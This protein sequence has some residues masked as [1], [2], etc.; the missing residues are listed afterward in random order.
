MG[1]EKNIKI[2]REKFG[3]TVKVKIPLL[4]G[5]RVR[6]HKVIFRAIKFKYFGSK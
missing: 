5:N 4:K 3:N 6:K 2:I 1:K